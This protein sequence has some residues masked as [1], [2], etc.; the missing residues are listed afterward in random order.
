M[1]LKGFLHSPAP[2]ILFPNRFVRF[3]LVYRA[4]QALSPANVY[5]REPHTFKETRKNE[6]SHTGLFTKGGLHFAIQE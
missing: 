6:T 1:E 4:G 3:R 2:H 5:Y